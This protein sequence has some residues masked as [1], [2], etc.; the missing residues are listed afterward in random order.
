MKSFLLHANINAAPTPE[1]CRVSIGFATL[2]FNSLFQVMELD[3][4]RE[5]YRL[6]TAHAL[7]PSKRQHLAAFFQAENN[8]RSAKDLEDAEG[9]ILANTLHERTLN[10]I[11]RDLSQILGGSAYVQLAY[12]LPHSTAQCVI[13]KLDKHGCPVNVNDVNFCALTWRDEAAVGWRIVLV[14]KKAEVAKGDGRLLGGGLKAQLEHLRELGHR[15]LIITGQRYFAAL[16]QKK[17]LSFLR[18]E[19]NLKKT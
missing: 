4:V 7:S 3:V 2:M 1:N 17:N 19:I 15:P 16:K 6:P 5:I 8:A 9:K 13:F 14:P 11:Y 10:F 12:P 18:K